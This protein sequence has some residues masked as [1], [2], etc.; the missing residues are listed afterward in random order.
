MSNF[1]T[2]RTR[3]TDRLKYKLNKTEKPG[4]FLGIER[5]SNPQPSDYMSYALPFELST[6]ILLTSTSTQVT[7][8][9]RLL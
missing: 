1:N 7:D 8:M 9:V 6:Q 4:K 3:K 2:V 5:V